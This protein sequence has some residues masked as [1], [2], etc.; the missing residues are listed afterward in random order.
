MTQNMIRA[1][2][3]EGQTTRTSTGRR[4][5]RGILIAVGVLFALIGAYIV[6]VAAIFAMTP[7]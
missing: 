6:F 7:D 2:G 1:G 5:A 4:I 3:T